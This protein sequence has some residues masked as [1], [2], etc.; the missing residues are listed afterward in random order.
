MRKLWLAGAA[1]V[2]LLAATGS[3][4]AEVGRLDVPRGL[5]VVSY[6]RSDAGWAPFWTDWRPERVAAELDRAASL[7]ANAVRA[8]VQP[9]AFVYPDP[10]AA[11]VAHLRE[12]VSLAAARGLH[13]QLT[14]FD[15]WFDWADVPGSRRWARDRKSTRLNSSHV[16]ISYAVFCLKK[17]NK[18]S[19]VCCIIKKKKIIY[20]YNY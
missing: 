15:Q 14:L 6:Y 1:L 11:F 2:V 20:I 12:F 17:K 3:S 16:A 13:V 7:H 10:A 19:I 18:I 4:G 8:I 5:K 9:A